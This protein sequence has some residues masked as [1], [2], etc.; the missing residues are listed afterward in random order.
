MKTRNL[1][2]LEFRR[3]TPDL[4][5][6]LAA[7]FEALAQQGAHR[8]FHPHPL[9]ES[10]ARRIA[11][12]EGLDLYYALVDGETVIGY[13][14]LRGWDEGFKVPSIG[15]AI[16][17]EARKQQVGSLLMQFLHCAARRRGAEE[18]LSKVHR[19]NEPSIRMLTGLGYELNDNGKE[20]LLGRLK[21]I[22]GGR[23]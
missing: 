5:P 12:Y 13:G 7:F 1:N 9:V 2:A 15:V 19:E 18:V 22:K 6:S 21:L 4:A 3:V 11:T 23:P 14:I 20:S 17:A 16:A 8:F 10:E